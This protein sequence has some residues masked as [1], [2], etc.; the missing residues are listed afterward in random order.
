MSVEPEEWRP[1]PIC[2]FDRY[3][4]SNLGRVRSWRARRYAG[5]TKSK[6]H[7]IHGGEDWD[8]YRNVGLMHSVSGKRIPVKVCKL[9]ALA[10]NG[11]KPDGK[12][13]AHD[14]GNPGDDRACNVIYKTPLENASDKHRHG[15]T[16]TENN[17]GKLTSQDVLH[18]RSCKDSWRLIALDFNIHV[19][20]VRN[21]KSGRTWGWL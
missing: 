11:P 4:V 13:V 6:P 1:V 20:T 10:F 2:G 21:I 17:N 9:V 3:E 14:N 19:S 16:V 15:T 8:G 18:I 7:I 12:E 5:R